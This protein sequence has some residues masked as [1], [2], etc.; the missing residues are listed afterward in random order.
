[1]S[2]RFIDKLIRVAN[3]VISTTQSAIDIR[4]APERETTVRIVGNLIL[5]PKVADGTV[6]LALI[7]VKD[8]VGTPVM[9]LTNGS[10]MFDRPA[11]V[12]WHGVYRIGA[13]SLAPY[14]IPIDVR[15]Q[16]KLRTD[17]KV[18][19]I[20]LGDTSTVSHVAGSLTYFCKLV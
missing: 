2:K 17:D 10:E 5:E 3:V 11:D 9:V 4:I 16:R 6:G 12:L 15:G 8:G 13:S 20:A 1:M 14:L 18:I 7:V 19:L